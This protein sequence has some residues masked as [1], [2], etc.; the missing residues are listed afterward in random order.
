MIAVPKNVMQHSVTTW[1]SSRALQS[2]VTA[3][4]FPFFDNFNAGCVIR[5][6]STLIRTARY[7]S[8]IISYSSESGTTPTAPDVFSFCSILAHYYYY[9]TN[10]QIPPPPPPSP[11]PLITI[12]APCPY[13]APVLPPMGSLSVAPG[14]KMSTDLPVPE[15]RVL[16]VASHVRRSQPSFLSSPQSPDTEI[17]YP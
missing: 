4:H 16:A 6:F 1:G 7:R 14:A 13:S 8:F 17:Q 10:P 5:N 15:T 3:G 12:I 9:E 2:A 11:P